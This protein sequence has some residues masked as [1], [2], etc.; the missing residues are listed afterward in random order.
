MYHMMDVSDPFHT[1]LLY[2]W[3]KSSPYP[4][5][6]RLVGFR[7]GLDIVAKIRTLLYSVAVCYSFRERDQSV[8]LLI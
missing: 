7:T 6:R 3:G 4:L 1:K 8:A 5:H 2:L